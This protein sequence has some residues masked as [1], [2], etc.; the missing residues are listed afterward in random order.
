MAQ[1]AWW[2]WLKGD[3]RGYSYYSTNTRD[4]WKD[5]TAEVSCWAMQALLGG[6]A[7]SITIVNQYFTANDAAIYRLY[8]WLGTHNLVYRIVD[9]VIQRALSLFKTIRDPDKPGYIPRELCFNGI[10]FDLYPFTYSWEE[11]R[12]LGTHHTGD[13]RMTLFLEH[14]LNEENLEPCG[15]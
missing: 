7:S 4:V 11:G 6:H 15:R 1:L 8:Q 9:L 2:S 10:D 13:S 12:G 14:A 3:G 5:N